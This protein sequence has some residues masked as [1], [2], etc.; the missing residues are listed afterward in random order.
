M[1]NSLNQ[2]E[3]L[4][5]LL[6]ST[7]DAAIASYSAEA[8][9]SA[10]EQRIMAR[11]S[12]LDAP[13]KP[14]GFQWLCILTMKRVLQVSI[15][16]RGFQPRHRIAVAFALIAVCAAVGW[17]TL[18]ANRNHPNSSITV[19]H[20]DNHGETENPVP[21]KTV[22][23][24]AAPNLAHRQREQQ[25]PTP[26]TSTED[27]TASEPEIFPSPTPLTAEERA[28]LVLAQHPPIQSAEA[29]PDAQT[30]QPGAATDLNP[31]THPD[32]AGTSPNAVAASQ[33]V[34][35]ISIAAIHIEPLPTAAPVYP[36]TNSNP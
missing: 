8:A 30:K 7:L 33:E 12:G 21:P 15:L 3:D 22:A 2:P 24:V 16:R 4:D 28:L 11:V 34:Q 18:R 6:D 36:S 27:H 31:A 25:R 23:A 9:P 17:M 13:A 14:S 35:P 29:T 20:N 10:L 26:R 32:P 19:A 5:R 1:Q